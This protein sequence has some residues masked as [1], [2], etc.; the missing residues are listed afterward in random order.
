VDET[1][2]LFCISREAGLALSEA[3][4]GKILSLCGLIFAVCQYFISASIYVRFGLYGSIRVGTILSAPIMFFVPISLLINPN[5]EV[6]D[7]P[8]PRFLYLSVTMAAYRIFS[9]VFFSSVGVA[10]NQSVPQSQR[11]SINGLAMLGASVAKGLGPAFAGVLVSS[12]VALL[13]KFGSLLIFGTIGLIGCGVMAFSFLFLHDDR[14]VGETT[15]KEDAA[16]T[17]ELIESKVEVE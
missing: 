17:I 4:I 9:L 7:L 5:T 14:E 11:A 12:S 6:G 2:P 8:W 16:Q 1:F 3:Q 13:G 10:L 15:T